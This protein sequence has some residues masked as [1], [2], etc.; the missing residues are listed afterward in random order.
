MPLLIFHSYAR[1]L[2][3]KFLHDAPGYHECLHC[4]QGHLYDHPCSDP[5][6]LCLNEECQKYTCGTHNIPW[7]QGYSCQEY[8]AHTSQEEDQNTIDNKL[9]MQKV[10]GESKAC[11]GCNRMI[12]RQGDNGD[13]GCEHMTCECSPHCNLQSYRSK[14]NDKIRYTVPMGV[15]LW[16]YGRVG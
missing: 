15:L 5:K 12:F 1:A 9:S 11:P 3:I 14:A 2:L 4:G 6:R 7:H 16:L 10:Q 13:D 8:D